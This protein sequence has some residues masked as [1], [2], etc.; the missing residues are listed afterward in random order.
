V[1]TQL[2][3]LCLAA[4]PK[5]AMLELLDM[6]SAAQHLPSKDELHLD[7]GTDLRIFECSQCGLVQTCQEPVAYYKEVIRASA[8]SSEMAAFRKKQ[9]RKWV[10]KYQ[11][12]NHSIL[13]IG[14]GKGEYLQLLQ[15]A[16]LKVY[17]TEFGNSAVQTCHH[18]G[19]EVFKAFPDGSGLNLKD[20]PF[21]AFASFNFMEHWPHPKKLSEM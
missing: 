5:K 10:N 14:T 1:T 8:F 19:F 11:L 15:Q 17:G 7:R 21:D 3:R 13:E 2:C 12:V 9:L 4:L 20:A 6:P 18:L 16:G